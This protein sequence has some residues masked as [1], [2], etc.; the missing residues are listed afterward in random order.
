[1]ADEILTVAE[2]AV[3]EKTG[4]TMAQRSE[5]LCFKVRRQW[6]FRRA[7]LDA[8][9]DGKT[10]GAAG[11]QDRSDEVL[12]GMG[13]PARARWCSTPT[14]V[15]CCEERSEGPLARALCKSGIV[16]RLARLAAHVRKP[17][18]HARRSAERSAR[19]DGSRRPS[20]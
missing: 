17:A 19:T 8:W 1:M 9:I 16:A 5:L 7:D 2:V 11:E 15:T 14:T 4:Y 18:G 20:T 10:R 6:R 3:A 13:A 12:R